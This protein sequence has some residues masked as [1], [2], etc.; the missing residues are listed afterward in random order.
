MFELLLPIGAIIVGLVLLIWS[1]DTFIDGASATASLFGVS[2]LLIGIFVLGFGTSAPEMVVSAIAA[3]E[4]T[5]ELAVGN[6]LGSNIANIGLVLGITALIAPLVV[7][8]STIK[9]EMPIVLAITV[10]SG[11]LLMDLH[12]SFMDGV[13]L[14]CALV[15]VLGYLTYAN[16]KQTQESTQADPLESE[17]EEVIDQELTKGKAILMMLIGLVILIISARMLVWGAVEVATWAGVSEVIIGLTIVAIGTSLPEL[18]AAISATLKKEDDLTIGNLLGSNLF[19]ILA[20]LSIPAL[21]SPT[22]L[23]PEIFNRDYWVM[24]AMTAFLIL[25]SFKL[26]QNSKIKRWHGVVFFGSY[27][28]YLGL[29]GAQTL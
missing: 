12:L 6:V 26:G 10:L 7:Q 9:R 8:S 19:N 29:L 5:P 18:A 25:F 22:A 2:T 15:V 13:I 20:V 17:V 28:S 3:I 16:Q 4:G 11:L 24:L 14:A 23:T 1:A 21:L 27:V